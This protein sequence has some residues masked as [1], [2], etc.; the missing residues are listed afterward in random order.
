MKIITLSM[1]ALA[2]VLFLLVLPIATIKI[3]NAT[4]NRRFETA[5][6]EKFHL[7][8]FDGLQMESCTFPSNKGQ[9]LTGYQYSKASSDPV[10]GVLVMAHGFGGGGHNLYMNVA[11]YFASNGYLVFAYDAT[12]N[13]AS[14]GDG[15]GGL[16]QGVIDLDHA[17]QYVKQQDIYQ[18]LPIVLFGHSWGGYSVGNVL[19]FHPDIKAAVMVAGFDRS[20]DMILQQGR[21]YAGAALPVL[22]PYATLYEYLKFGKYAQCSALTGF[23]NTDA[24]VMIFHSQ[25]DQIVLAENGYD[26]FYAAYSDS[27]RFSF[28]LYEDRGHGRI[29][30]LET[31]N[32]Y[33]KKLDPEVMQEML[34]F[35]NSAVG[36]DD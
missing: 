8:K 19:N 20:I 30:S 29:Y 32:P 34:S 27:P 22:I 24:Q 1:A 35:Y 10:A 26:K 2:A 9:M 5:H 4:F 28:S 12:G 36:L 13:D 11:D 14:E 16:P 25:D 17:L 18:G 21:E 23:A 7:S 15:V 31:G 6:A 33:I 3:Y